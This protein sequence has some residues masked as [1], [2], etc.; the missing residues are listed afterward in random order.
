MA[1]AASERHWTYEAG[2]WTACEGVYHEGW[3]RRDRE[4]I[5]KAG[6]RE[7]PLKPP[8]LVRA[9]IRPSSQGGQFRVTVELG[10][11]PELILT[12]GLGNLVRLLGEL[13]MAGLVG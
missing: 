7:L 6:F 13:R 11:G 12:E 3:N 5:E 1:H 8:T 2:E 10:H 4:F 9:W